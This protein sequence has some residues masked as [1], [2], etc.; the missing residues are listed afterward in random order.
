[1]ETRQEPLTSPFTSPLTSPL[2]TLP[3]RSPARLRADGDGA[4]QAAGG[5]REAA[6]DA[7]RGVQGPVAGAESARRP[8]EDAGREEPT[9]EAG[10]GEP[11]GGPHS[12]GTRRGA[13]GE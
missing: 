11:R 10:G 4:A 6:G 8:A 2:L 12:T 7:D 13:A 1:M 5:I 3:C 9:A